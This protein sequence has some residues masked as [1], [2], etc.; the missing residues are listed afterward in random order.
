MVEL[1]PELLLVGALILVNGIL[2]GSEI[3]LISLRESQLR[4]MERRGGGGKVVARLARD[5]NRFLATIQ[6][7]ITLSGF[8]ASAAAAVSLAEPLAPVLGWFGASAETVAIVLVTLGLSFLT[9]VLGELV[10]KRLALQRA[11]GWALLL[12]RPL[13]WLAVASAPAVWLLSVATDLT[14]RLFGGKPDSAREAV[15]ADELREMIA[16]NRALRDHHQEV[17]LGA[18]EVAERRL[19]QVLV[20]RPAVFSLP[21]AMGKT[22]AIAALVEAG[23]TRAPVVPTGA[24]LDQATSIVSLRDLV[25]ASETKSV[26]DHARAALSIPETAPVLGALR[27]MQ[28]E[29]QQMALVVD[30]F[31]GVAGIV[32][33]E[34]LIEEVVG[35][36]YDETDRDVASAEIA[37]NGAIVVAGRFPIHDLTDLGV[38]L[39]SGPYTTVAGLILHELGTIPDEP[40]DSLEIDGWEVSVLA[41]DGRTIDKVRLRRAADRSGGGGGSEPKSV[42]GSHGSVADQ[43]GQS[44]VE[45]GDQIGSGREDQTDFT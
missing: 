22:E 15:D 33:I 44:L 36:I 41:M 26:G 21:E 19:A 43:F 7:G 11:E 6:I 9:L 45:G 16:A 24:G 37:A 20:A 25:G 39:P 31:G 34:D 1:W 27:Q 18:F 38:D 28:V 13:H 12:G 40:G 30:E 4:R 23:H 32:T 10:P 2:A 8:L 14:V 35:E 42:E 17:L 3:A 5:P 29:R